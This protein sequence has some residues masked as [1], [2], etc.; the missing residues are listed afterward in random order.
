MFAT[1]E[2]LGTELIHVSSPVGDGAPLLDCRV[3]GIGRVSVSMPA[4]GDG[5]PVACGWLLPGTTCACPDFF[6]L[7]CKLFFDFIHVAIYF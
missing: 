3:E 5:D 6:F 2:A 7:Q 4:V 1:L